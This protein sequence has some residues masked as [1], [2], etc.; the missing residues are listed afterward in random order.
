M[1]HKL[2]SIHM[3]ASLPAAT[4]F[5]H[6]RARLAALFFTALIAA[7]LSLLLM[8]GLAAAQGGSQAD[9]DV[10]TG[11]SVGSSQPVT[12][13]GSSIVPFIGPSTD[14]PPE[15]EVRGEV[16]SPAWLVDLMA[17]ND[18]RGVTSHELAISKSARPEAFNGDVLFYTI[19][20]TNLS[21]NKVIT[22][23]SVR[24]VLPRGALQDIGCLGC[25]R[26]FESREIPE[27]LGG[28]IVVTETRELSWTITS[29][30]PGVAVSRHFSGRIVGQSDGALIKNQA[31]ADYKIGEEAHSVSSDEVQT[32]IFVSTV[33]GVGA[34]I[35]KAPNWF[36]SDRGGT[37]GLDWGDY[38]RDGYLDLAMAS[39][40]GTTVYRNDGGQM[41]RIW[42]STRPSFGVR[43]GDFTGDNRLELVVVGDQ[44]DNGGVNYIYRVFGATVQEMQRFTSTEQLARVA[45]GDFD[46][47]GDLDLI[48]ST[49]SINALCPV[50]LYRNDGNANFSEDP[51]CI[52]RRATASIGVG[53]VDNDGDLDLVLGLFPNSLQLFR[54]DGSGK[55]SPPSSPNVDSTA[56]F[57]PYDFAWGD[58]DGDGFLDLAAAYPLMRQARI[59][60]NNRGNGFDAPIILRTERFLTPFSLD[61]GDFTGDGRLDLALGDLSPTIYS[62]ENGAFVKK[63]QLTTNIQ[64]GQAWALRGV[65]IDNDGDLDLTLTNR[66]G[67]SVIFTNFAPLL[68]T[69]LTR[70]PATTELSAAPASSV[71][72]A[73]LNG[74]GLL[75]LLFGA[76]PN[77]VS[78]KVYANT[79]G[80][81]DREDEATLG[82]FGPHVVAV[83]DVD[84]DGNLD[85]AI[86]TGQTILLYLA[87]N[88][89]AADWTSAPLPARPT[90]MIWGDYD[91]DGDLDLLVATAGDSLLLYRNQGGS[92]GTVALTTQPVWR[93][94]DRLNATSLAWADLNGDNYL[95]FAVGVDGAPNRIYMNNLIGNIGATEIFSRLD[96][97]QPAI[98]NDA[99]RVVAWGDYNGDGR[100]DL[101]VGN[102][103]SSNLIYRNESTPGVVAFSSSPVWASNTLSKTTALA[104]G[105][106]DN[107]GDLDLAVG[108]DGEAD[109]VYVNRSGQLL[110]LWSSPEQARTTGVA[111][112]DVDNDGDLDLAVSQVEGGRNGF[113]ANTLVSPAHLVDDYGA[114]VPL[115]NNPRYLS[116]D[117]PGLADS[118]YFYSSPQILAGSNQAVVMVTYRL[119]DPNGRRNAP[120]SDAAG[121]AIPMSALSFEYSLD[122]GGSWRNATPAT[123]ISP[124]QLLTPTR[125][126]LA[127]TFLWNA[128]ADKA[129]SENALFRVVLAQPDRV[130]PV[131]RAVAAAVSP[132][133]R[134]RATSCLWPS[135]LR[136]VQTPQNPRAGESVTFQAYLVASGSLSAVWN[137][138]DGSTASGLKVNHSF[139]WDGAYPVTV[140]VQGEACPMAR[141]Q[142]LTALVTVGSGVSPI[143]LPLIMAQGASARVGESDGGSERAGEGMSEP[144]EEAAQASSI[145]APVTGFR[146]VQAANGSI[147][148]R[149]DRPPAS[150]GVDGYRLWASLDGSEFEPTTDL[151]AA[152]STYRLTA[153]VCGSVYFITALGDGSESPPSDGAFY[154]A[155]CAGGN[156]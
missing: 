105:D 89:A 123:P 136:I 74:D 48:V 142:S 6:R 67:P 23:V 95:D 39:S 38:D 125:L 119:Y 148:L 20:I 62:F 37:L 112:G 106:W 76:G 144:D 133:F 43:W 109:Q 14:L 150:S 31:F 122:G 97:W 87:G 84:K 9:T 108:N 36:S 77:E 134:V 27:P 55:F 132:P 3:L 99:T 65:D 130:G 124:T 35:S 33:E 80:N 86:G 25:T 26:I 113:Y 102:Y 79:Q 98:Q 116:V 63:E 92:A 131:S 152:R 118:A 69:Q 32:R 88:I 100:P 153:P 126:G 12:E 52:S 54:N 81:F 128:R 2:Y 120:G 60:R 117:R 104:W 64:S 30:G 50:L 15:G 114:R 73:D 18:P 72:W 101:T 140:N 17:R 135:N 42:S 5:V 66:D 53:D 121:L 151:E 127:Q 147:T 143:Y 146:G 58:Y 56:T 149:W 93:S 59:Y 110:W 16:E 11:V 45:P 107:D 19:T 145:P 57:L 10:V 94:A 44:G 70:A 91:D 68:S 156:E 83:G 141:R 154:A 1:D 139:V 13:T 96:S 115:P 90:A 4:S 40:V 47:D 34:S 138:G 103:G 22:N 71:V 82:G 85:I 28:S 111:W 49:N 137:F 78:S 75:D 61:W 129:I 51:T 41:R 7:S 24:D 8:V 29:L 46:G 21:S 155:P